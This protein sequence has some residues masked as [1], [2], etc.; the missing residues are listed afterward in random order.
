[1]PYACPYCL[2]GFMSVKAADECA[3]ACGGELDEK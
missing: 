3:R 2:T 1:M